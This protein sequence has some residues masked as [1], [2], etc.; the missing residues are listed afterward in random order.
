MNK[1]L[2]ESYVSSLNCLNKGDL[3]PST[4]FMFFE[5]FYI[6]NVFNIV[7]TY[8]RGRKRSLS[9]PTILLILIES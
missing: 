2:S 9:V 6:N 3:H 1:V 4:Y 5:H 8:I 7:R